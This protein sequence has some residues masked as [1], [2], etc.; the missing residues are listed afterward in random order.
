MHS[1]A[2]VT[3]PCVRARFEIVEHTV[4]KVAGI[5]HHLLGQLGHRLVLGQPVP[6]LHELGRL[7]GPRSARV[8]AWVL[9]VHLLHQ[10]LELELVR[11]VLLP[12]RLLWLGQHLG[13][14]PQLHGHDDRDLLCLDD[15]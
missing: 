12:A 13:V 4:V 3:A 15:K 10:V 11:R 5:A 1:A 14:P 7:F 6:V 8:V 2:E 9:A